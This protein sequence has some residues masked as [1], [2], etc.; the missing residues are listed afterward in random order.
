MYGSATLDM[1]MLQL[2]IQ[3]P[4]TW[5]VRMVAAIL[6]LSDASVTPSVWREVAMQSATTI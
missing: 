5:N 2:S 6:Q 4:T 1:H 3:S